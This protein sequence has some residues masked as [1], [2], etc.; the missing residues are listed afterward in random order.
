MEKGT[1]KWIT[2]KERRDVKA[3][4][5]YDING[6]NLWDVLEPLVKT[7]KIKWAEPFSNPQSENQENEWNGVITVV[8]PTIEYYSSLVPDFRNDLLRKKDGETIIEPEKIDIEE[9]E[10]SLNKRI[11]EVYDDPSP[12]NKSSV[13]FMF[14]PA[15]GKK[16]LFT[17]D[18]CRDSFDYFKSEPLY[19]SLSNIDWLKVPHH[20]SIHNLDSTMITHFCPN[21][22]YVS[23]KE[24]NNYLSRSIVSALKKVKTKVYSTSKNGSMWH[25]RGTKDRDDYSTANPF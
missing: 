14:T 6:D 5:V 10:E 23:T 19:E 11:D 3:R 21:I 1:I 8:G 7:G 12:H 16:Y 25:H 9:A 15:D 2:D 13:I 17:G 18:A 4:S 22:A 24:F 20:G